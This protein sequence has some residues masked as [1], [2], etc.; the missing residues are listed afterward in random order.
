MGAMCNFLITQMMSVESKVPKLLFHLNPPLFYFYC[1]GQI[2]GV[3][4]RLCTVFTSWQRK[5]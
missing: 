4:E 2:C 5:V 3:E 1:H